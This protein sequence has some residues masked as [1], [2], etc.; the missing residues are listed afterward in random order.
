MQ[1]FLK[2]KSKPS[3]CAVPV[4]NEFV[5]Y[6]KC[7]ILPT[8]LEINERHRYDQDFCHPH[9]ILVCTWGGFHFA[10]PPRNPKGANP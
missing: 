10:I 4:R 8:S 5:K 3:R 2:K 1:L 6:V 7:F 9:P